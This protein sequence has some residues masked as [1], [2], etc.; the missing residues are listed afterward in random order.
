MNDDAPFTA[1]LVH[2]S[3]PAEAALPKFLQPHLPVVEE[4]RRYK[5]VFPSR[6]G[7]AE[8]KP[9]PEPGELGE[10]GKVIIVSIWVDVGTSG[11]LAE[12]VVLLLVEGCDKHSGMGCG[13]T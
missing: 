4:V 1:L 9:V 13:A 5:S 3:R 7:W 6:G 12:I 11:K 8:A 10:V 2:W